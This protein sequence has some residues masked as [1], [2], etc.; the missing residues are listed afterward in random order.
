MKGN[1][2]MDLRNNEITL[3]EIMNNKD[4][5]RLIQTEFG[6]MLKGPLFAMA[7]K[8][9]LAKIMTYADGKISKDKIEDLLLKLKNI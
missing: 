7:K 8:M 9:S 4:A 2:I 6:H 1:E 5:S 3:G